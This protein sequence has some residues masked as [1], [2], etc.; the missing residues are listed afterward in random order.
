MEADITHTDS[1][2]TT[3]IA[4]SI[5]LFTLC[6]AVAEPKVLGKMRVRDHDCFID[7]AR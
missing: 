1:Q 4:P 6:F 3:T 2:L 7:A 5:A